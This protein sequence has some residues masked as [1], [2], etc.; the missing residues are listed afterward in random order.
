MLAS[1][2]K[3]SKSFLA[4]IFIAIIALPFILWGMG[5]VFTSGKQNVIAEINDEKISSKEFI[6]Y[7][8]KVKL[9]KNEIERIGRDKLFDDMLSNYL[10]EKI[11]R[12]EGKKKGI[13]LSDSGLKKILVADK[14]FQKDKKFSRVKYEKFLLESG[15]TAPTYER[16]IKS[17]ELKGQLLNYYSGGIKLP[18][19]IVDDL[20]KK[21]N[22]IKEI[23]FIN[24]NQIYTKKIIQEKE[25]Q[26]FYDE[27][28]KLFEEE[29]VSFKYLELKP[30]ILTKKK[31]FDEEYYEKLDE[32]ENKIL[33]GKKFSEII[34]GNEN[35]IKEVDLINARKVKQ[36]GTILKEIDNSF[37]EKVFSIKNINSPEFINLKNKYFIA[38]LTDKKNLILTLNDKDLKKTINLQLKFAFKIKENKKL[39]DEIKNNKF[40]KNQMIKFA[41]ENNV[42]ISKI[43]IDGIDDFKRFSKDFNTQIYNRTTGDIFLLSDDILKDNFLVNILTSLEPKINKN[44]EKYKKYLKKA[45]SEYISKVYKSYDNYINANYKIDINEK[46]L[47]RLKNSF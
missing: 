24:L 34:T 46:V 30:E 18:N 20:Y 40:N 45:N 3:F 32:V 10:S 9:T 41:K 38:V 14:S 6:T 29:F 17:I 28:K 8:Q 19:F 11:I 25:I 33:D 42:S 1:I 35:N 22:Q 26:K 43:K 4:K 44:S 37:I 12:I 13:Q 39:I 7:L 36:D 21:E 16:F 31:V 47:E 27:N 15:Y 2:R 5:D 23:E